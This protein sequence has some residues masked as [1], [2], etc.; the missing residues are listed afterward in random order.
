MLPVTVI[1][2]IP[3][4]PWK[5]ARCSP[6][7]KV[8]TPPAAVRAPVAALIVTVPPLVPLISVPKSRS[9]VFT[10]VFGRT[11]VAVAVP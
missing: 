10:S 1:R 7:P 2:M 9:S 8:V 3:P 11:T 5:V 6:P 4:V